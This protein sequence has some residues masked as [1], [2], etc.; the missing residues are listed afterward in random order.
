M[1]PRILTA[2][3][4]VTIAGFLVLLCSTYF[5]RSEVIRLNEIR[6]RADDA[7]AKHNLQEH[8]NA[9]DDREA[10]YQAALKHHAIEQQHYRDMLEL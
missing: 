7:L 5:L 8:R 3:K 2:I 10:E 9:H 1:S 4:G 6:F